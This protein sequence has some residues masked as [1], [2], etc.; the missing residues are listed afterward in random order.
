MDVE[1]W[2]RY[3]HR[4]HARIGPMRAAEYRIPVFRV[5]SSG[6]SQIVSSRGRAIETKQFPGSS[7]VLSGVLSLGSPARLPIDRWLVWPA[8]LVTGA[9]AAWAFWLALW[10]RKKAKDPSQSSNPTAEPEISS[11]PA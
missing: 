6:I 7:E 1:D 3:Q 4:L 11:R 5:A 9:V 8:V 10:E 2:G